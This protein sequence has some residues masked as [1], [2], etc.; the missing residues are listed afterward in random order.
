MAPTQTGGGSSL[1]P[2]SDF[3]DQMISQNTK[4]AEEALAFFSILAVIVLGGFMTTVF[5]TKLE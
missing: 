4:S 3:I 2:L 1:P 5:K